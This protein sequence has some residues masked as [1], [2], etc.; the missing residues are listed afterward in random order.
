MEFYGYTVSPT[1]VSLTEQNVAVLRAMPYPTSVSET[2]HV[3]GVLSVS[4]KWVHH[5][6][7][8]MIPLYDLV[9]KN[10]PFKWT[11]AHSAAMDGVREDL[12]QQIKLTKF[13][14]AKQLVIYSDA[15]QAGIGSFLGPTERRWLT[16][17]HRVLQ[18]K[19]VTRHA[20]E[21]G[22]RARSIWRYH[23]LAGGKAI[24][25]VLTATDH[26]LL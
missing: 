26:R 5:F 12:I 23:G 11:P 16:R 19:A 17:D 8:R 1:G 15:S 7:E 20:E 6:A 3:I 25:D 18:Q 22:D 24:C 9:K 10:I 13:D 14:P 4:K 21:W 2:R